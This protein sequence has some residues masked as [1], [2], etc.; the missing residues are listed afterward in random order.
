MGKTQIFQILHIS[1]L[2]VNT[3]ENFDRSVV[4]DPLIERVK[5]D[6]ENGFKPEI[7]VVTGDIAYH[8]I[9]DEYD[10]AKAFF[11][12]LRENLKLPKESVFIVP[13]NHDVNREK[14]LKSSGVPTYNDMRDLNEELEKEYK[15]NKLFEGLNEYFTFIE[16]NY[17]HLKSKHGR[18][19]PFVYSYKALCRKKIGLVGLN[20][21]WMCRKSPDESSIKEKIAI[22]EYQTKKAIE[23]LKE[24]GNVNLQ[25]NLFHHPLEWL[26]LEDRSK[27][28][29]YLNNSIILTGH[30][31][32]A[33]GGY[34]QEY[35][36]SLCQFQVGGAYLGSDSKKP[37][38]FQYISFD[39]SENEIRLDFRKYHEGKWVLDGETGDDGHKEFSLNIASDSKTRKKKEEQI[40][41]ANEQDSI[42]GKYV[43][44][45]SNEHR[46]LPMQG[47]E[48]NLRVPIEIERVYVNMRAHIHAYDLENRSRKEVAAGKEQ[49]PSLDI[50]K[51]FE[52]AETRKIKDMV[53]LGDPGS[54]KTTLLKYILI[55]LIDG[56]GME[57]IGLDSNIIPF[58][59]P[60]REL[61]DPDNEDLLDFIKRICC[62]Y[63]CEIS[64]EDFKKLLNNNRGIILLDG[65]DEVADEDAR[66]KTCRWI[67]DARKK[68]VHTRF[69]ITS[70]L[71]GYM[72]KSRLEGQ[73]VLELSIQNFTPDEIKSFLIRW[74]ESVEAAMLPDAED[75]WMKKGR[76]QALQLVE[77]IEKSESIKK[78]AV[79]PLLLQIIALVRRDRG[80]VLPQRRVELYQECVNVLLEKWDMAKGLD[81]LLS[82]SQARRILQPVA[83]W[84]HEK[85]KER[86][87]PL[88]EIIDLIKEPLE[89]IGKS[90]ID[91][92]KLLYNIRDRAGIF[93]GYS[94]SEYGFSHLSFQE[95]IAAEHIRNTRQLNILTDNYN[96]RWWREVTLLCL[97]LD[98]PSIIE[99]FMKIIIQTEAFKSDI[100]LITDAIDDSIIKPAKPFIEAVNNHDLS[101]DVKRNAIRILKHVSS[102]GARV[103]IPTYE[104]A[105]IEQRQM[106]IINDIDNSKMALIPEGDF[107]YGSRE[108]DKVAGSSEKPQRVI[109]LPSF[110]MDV[111]PVTNKQFCSFLNSTNPGEKNLNKWINLEGSFR[112]EKCRIRKERNKYIVEKG[113]EEHPVIYV[114]WYGANAYA[115]WAGKRLP[116]EQEWEKASRGTDG[117]IYPWGGEFNRKLCNTD[118]SGRGG[119][120][121]VDEY[122]DGK[123]PYGCYDMAGNVWEWTASLYDE[124]R[125]AYVLRGGSWGID[126]D[127][128][129]CAA[130]F[131]SVPLDRYDDVGFRCARAQL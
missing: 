63:N 46:H 4:L 106:F 121:P 101:D 23:E 102:T 50:K 59:A 32:D 78:L 8:G 85:E 17:P 42:F 44:Y 35:G 30:L 16:K 65:L 87:A 111:F 53:I 12:D 107:L 45:A 68:Y 1:D 2:H 122:P 40:K 124:Y 125:D 22:G 94:E 51:A 29:T 86:H 118:E 52:I 14:Y 82:A 91:P 11:Y 73:P 126:R 28:K 71:A 48:T 24:Q 113:Y 33:G 10:H 79:N 103:D 109:N 41:Q 72:G 128:C 49:L 90:G 74:F 7:V 108:D 66:I 69:V 96:N 13:G 123:S 116:T 38:R 26:W 130:R 115:K 76:E 56:K 36:S 25:I 6:R 34:F 27:C 47:F 117:R 19:I 60:L 5:E 100:T 67:D 70:R 120:S 84:L 110:Y 131:N 80:T 57:R 104:D 98:N 39:W 43:K 21:A 112:K 99:D 92:Q 129:R 127:Y 18:L 83:L 93:T 58:F 77:E 105:E 75:A 119:T 61:K 55:M 20:S 81:I 95:F 31:H 62:F 15:R 37:A 114:S 97:G 88:K 9:K 64:G 54:G 3:K 89:I